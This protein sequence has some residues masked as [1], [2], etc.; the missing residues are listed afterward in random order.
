MKKIIIGLVVVVVFFVVAYFAF[1]GNKRD[2]FQEYVVDQSDILKPDLLLVSSGNKSSILS[3]DE[4]RGL[5]QM[6]E[7]EKLARD[8]YTTLGEKWGLNI[9]SNI[10]ISEQ[11]HTDMVKVLLERYGVNDPVKDNT[12]GVFYS[13]AMKN[14]Y[15]DF[16]TKGQNS[17]VDALIVGA[18]IEDLDIHDLDLFLKGTNKDDIQ[19]TY[20]NLQ[21]GSR[22]HMRGFIKN[23]QVKGVDYRPQYIS[24]ELF[25]SIIGSSQE[26]GR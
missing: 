2:K 8:V 6:R 26:R 13:D 4:I 25:D 12:V 1:I 22:N 14:L 15:K 19:I 21:R 9:F 3:Q 16:T 10:A 24:K 23:L 20:S 17:L 5:I 11:T 7:E 18:T